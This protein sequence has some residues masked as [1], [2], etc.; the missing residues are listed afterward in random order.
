MGGDD[1][2]LTEAVSIA[3]GGMI[4]G[5]IYAVLGVVAG[6]TRAAWV[7]FLA[8]GVVS[9]CAGYSYTR[10]N[11]MT[12]NSGGSVT[13]VQCYLGNSD[14][15][16]MLGWTLLFGY[17]GSM[18]MYAFA[19]GEFAVSFVGVPVSVG[20][21]PARPVVSVLAVAGFVALNLAGART[22]GSAENLLVAAKVAILLAFGALGVAYA[23]GAAP[24]TGL[25]F[26]VGEL[27]SVGPVVAAA[28]SFVAFQGWQLL[29]YDQESIADAER[30][31]RRA[32]FVA[33]PAAVLVYVLVAVVT[34]SL[35]PG[36]LESHPHLALK[37][38]ARTMLTPY[39][40]G[41]LG[42]TVLA[43]SALFSTGSAINATMFSSAHLAKGMLDDD[44]LPDRV[45]DGDANGAPER[46]L[47]LLGAVT[48][49]FTAVGSL[50]A[51][52]SFASLSFIVV[53]GAMSLL[54]LR[55][56]D[57]ESVHPAPPA[58]G[59]LGAG[60]FLPLMANNLRTREPETFS[61]VLV[62]VVLV[63]GV[64]LLYFKHEALERRVVPIES[65]RIDD[66]LDGA[67]DDAIEEFAERSDEE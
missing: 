59:A 17:V 4:G 62:L 57:H 22:S 51:I 67:L 44:L 32:V 52:T 6:I 58:V 61:A 13:F 56:R 24:R 25:A 31:I 35:A 43:L 46:T 64:E 11:A 36:A 41:A 2:G 1:L 47:A 66:A 10:L 20:G 53:F 34:V 9:L 21:V 18:A 49:A 63:V 55:E 33:I 8:A 29:F 3:L 37:D 45:G 23:L 42:G 50:N 14:L 39:G 15:A 5:G 26:G 60:L 16:G 19:F 12:D 65:E 38:A 7:A 48:A 27:S 54:C 30:T 28:V 40:L